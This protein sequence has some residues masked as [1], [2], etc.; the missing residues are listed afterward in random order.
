MIYIVLI[1]LLFI[2]TPLVQADEEGKIEIGSITDFNFGGCP[3]PSDKCT[4]NEK[5]LDEYPFLQPIY[6]GD[7]VSVGDNCSFLT[8]MLFDGDTVT[9]GKGF[10]KNSETFTN[11]VNKSSLF[12]EIIR[13]LRGIIFGSESDKSSTPVTREVLNNGLKLFSDGK[14]DSGSIPY[15]DDRKRFFV[16]WDDP[17][18]KANNNGNY[19]YKLSFGVDNNADTAHAEVCNA[20]NIKVPFVILSF[21]KPLPTGK[22]WVDIKGEYGGISSTSFWVEPFSTEPYSGHVNTTQEK[23]IPMFSSLSDN[24]VRSKFGVLPLINCNFK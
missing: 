7:T 23:L 4:Y 24:E 11:T 17:S 12:T 14:I 2:V 20:E 3:C 19:P 13:T 15:S 5:A 16:T 21:N 1:L 18:K 8:V 22:Y 9:L 10:D 6:N